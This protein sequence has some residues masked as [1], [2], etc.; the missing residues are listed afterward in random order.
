MNE[1]IATKFEW[2]KSQKLAYNSVWTIPDRYMSG[3]KYLVLDCVI[4]V[5]LGKLVSDSDN[6][7]WVSINCPI[8][9]EK[10]FSV[11]RTGY[12]YWG[13]NGGYAEFEIGGNG[14]SISLLDA[15]VNGSNERLSSIEWY[16]CS[17][18]IKL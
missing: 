8:V 16:V 14:S 11:L 1:Y 9:H 2:K 5:N 7:F 13:N 10:T 17:R 15:Y 4:M 3:A 6:T 18:I 12:F